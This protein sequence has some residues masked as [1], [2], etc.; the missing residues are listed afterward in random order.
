MVRFLEERRGDQNVE[1]GNFEMEEFNLF[2]EE[3]EVGDIPMVGLKYTRFRPNGRA[4]S[5]LDR[6]FISPSWVDR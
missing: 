3:M 4:K 5:C 6:I 1:V 2:I